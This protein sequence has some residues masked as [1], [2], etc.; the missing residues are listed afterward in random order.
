MRDYT[1]YYNM[2]IVYTDVPLNNSMS[3]K[4]FGMSK[5]KKKWP[6]NL[7]KARLISTTISTV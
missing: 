3:P 6:V 2:P 4:Q 1:L 5:K 7:R